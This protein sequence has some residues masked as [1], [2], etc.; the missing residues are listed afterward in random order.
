MLVDL[1]LIVRRGDRVNHNIVNLNAITGRHSDL[2]NRRGIN[3][4]INE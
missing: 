4:R 2:L 3:A 1:N